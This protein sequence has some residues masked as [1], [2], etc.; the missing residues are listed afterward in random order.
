MPRW[1]SPMSPT[2]CRVAGHVRRTEGHR[3]VFGGNAETCRAAEY[4]AFIRTVFLHTV[5]F[6]DGRSAHVRLHR[7]AQL[8]GYPGSG[9]G[10]L[11][12]SKAEKR[13]RLG[14][15]EMPGWDPSGALSMS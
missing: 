1:S 3:R 9:T 15:D 2:N 6:I 7:L 14:E 5:R 12:G 11:S 10:G 13:H 8:A 4:L